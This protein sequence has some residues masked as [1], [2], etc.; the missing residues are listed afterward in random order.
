MNSVTDLKSGASNAGL[1]ARR[2]AALPR[3]VGQAH[4]VFAQRAEN[5]EIWDVEGRRWID[6]CAGIAVLN[7]GHRHPKV[8]AAARAQLEAYTHTCFQVVAYEGYVALCERLNKLMPGPTPKKSFLMNSGA[9]AVENAVKIARAHTGRRGVIAFGGGFHGRTM[10]TM[11]LTGKV[12]PYKIKFGPFAGDIY[13]VPYPD[14]LHGITE[15]EAFTAIKRLF[16]WDIEASDVAAIIVEPVQG[17]GGYIPASTRFMQGLRALCDEHGIVLIV[18]EVQSGIARCGKFFAIEHHQVEPDILTTAKGLGGGLVISGVVG[19]A[20][21]MDA[22]VPGGLGGTYSGNPVAVATANAVLDVIEE[23]NLVAR[24][25]KLGEHMRARLLALK[26]RFDCIADVRGLG[27]MTAV[28]FCHGGKPESPA[29]DIATALKNEAAKRGLLLLNCGNYGNV[30]RIMI[31][32]TIP[33]ALLD[34]GL[35]I[36]EAALATVTE[37]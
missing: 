34:E 12:D 23:E 6:F 31:P 20:A 33:F 30:L 24:A 22:P 18:D 32:L 19:K 27:A 1:M 28:E 11:A 2:A 35:D 8:M 26:A 36:I 3:G 17:E 14:P 5:A 29:G 37:G 15:D 9:E 25:A 21:I 7:T 10:F 4:P 13:H 16:K